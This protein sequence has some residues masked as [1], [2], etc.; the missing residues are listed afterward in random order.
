MSWK[1]NNGRDRTATGGIVW[2][3]VEVPESKT[4]DRLSPGLICVGDISFISAG[5]PDT[6]YLPYIADDTSCCQR[7]IIFN[8]ATFTVNNSVGGDGIRYSYIDLSHQVLPSGGGLNLDCSSIIDVSTIG[9]CENIVLMQPAGKSIAIGSKAGGVT[10]VGNQGTQD[11]KSI[12]IG[13]N[14]GVTQVESCISIGDGACNVGVQNDYGIAI[15]CLAASQGQTESAISIGYKSG[16]TATL[17]AEGIAIGLEAVCTAPQGISIGMNAKV[18]KS[19]SIALNAAATPLETVEDAAF[20][21]D[22]IRNAVNDNTL[23][24]D[25]SKREITYHLNDVNSSIIF[26]PADMVPSR[27]SGIPGFSVVYSSQPDPA[28]GS[29]R[30]Y[31]ATST[32][33]IICCQRIIPNGYKI[34]NA[35]TIRINSFGTLSGSSQCYVSAQSLDIGAAVP[36]LNLLSKTGI[37]VNTDEP[38]SGGDTATEGMILTVFFDNVTAGILVSNGPTAIVVTMSPM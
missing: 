32:S 21:V 6:P 4:D 36:L 28:A 19:N 26:T 18:T 20:Y 33:G 31:V 15:G 30:A 1:K 14:A 3:P 38:L 7:G 9:F 24:Y 8:K 25:T 12:A 5:I 10:G 37:V 2:H 13:E 17:A 35:N 16:G 22:P 27:R 23:Y 11:S 34:S 29:S